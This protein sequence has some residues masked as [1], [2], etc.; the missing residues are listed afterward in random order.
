[1]GLLDG[2]KSVPRLRAGADAGSPHSVPSRVTSSP[3]SPASMVTVLSVSTASMPDSAQT[4]ATCSC[5]T[6]TRIPPNTKSFLDGADAR[7]SFGE[8]VGALGVDR[9]HPECYLLAVDG[10]VAD[11]PDGVGEVHPSQ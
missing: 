4:S 9:G 6:V 11:A 8:G 1:M 3:A 7:E 2:L 10:I 5:W